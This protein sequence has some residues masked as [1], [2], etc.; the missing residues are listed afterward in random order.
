MRGPFFSDT[1]NQGCGSGRSICFWVSWIRIW[2]R[3]SEERIR[4]LLSSSKNSKKNL[5][6]Y[7][8]VTSFWLFIWTNDVHVP[9][10][11]SK[12]KNFKWQD[13]DPLDRGK[14]CHAHFAPRWADWFR[15]SLSF[16]YSWHQ[17]RNNRD[18]WY[19]FT[20]RGTYLPTRTLTN[21]Q[22]RNEKKFGWLW[23]LFCSLPVLT[24]TKRLYK[25]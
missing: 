1:S 9:S 18:P 13:P 2:I 16:Q 10:N 25:L 4:I 7:C 14:Y 3:Q 23:S 22:K 17:L 5:D 12:Q 15:M 19:L 8:F 21:G 24:G 6:S 11:S 20:Y